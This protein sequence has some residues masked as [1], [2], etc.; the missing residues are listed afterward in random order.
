M[1]IRYC[2]FPVPQEIQW[3]ETTAG[4]GKSQKMAIMS[5]E[6]ADTQ[7]GTL[8]TRSSLSLRFVPERLGPAWL[9]VTHTG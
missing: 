7:L 5:D 3:F 1:E 8:S 6:P 9:L 2:G 4:P